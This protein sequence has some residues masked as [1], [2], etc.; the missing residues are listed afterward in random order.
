M[1][2]SKF[3]MAAIFCVTLMT[4]CSNN[5]DDDPEEVLEEELITDVSLTFVNTQD[6]TDTVIMTSTAPDGQD[7]MSVEAING[8]FTAGAT[9]ALTIG[10][11]N[12]ED[13]NDP[14][15]V[16]NGDIIPEADE[17]FIAYAVSGINLTMSRDANDV[18]GPDD[19]KLGVNTTWV[20]G[21]ASTGNVQIRLIHEPESVDD[22]NGFGSATGG[23]EDFNIT[24]TGVIIE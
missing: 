12:S 11:L 21:D 22:S 6:N 23:S 9:Y 1:K 17:H 13:A 7:G 3:F 10:I 16:L 2:T 20:A 18:A 15:D 19:S 5:N 24:F 8:T 14:E 4:S